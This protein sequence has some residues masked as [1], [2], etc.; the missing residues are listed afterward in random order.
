[1]STVVEAPVEMIERVTGSP[2]GCEAR[3]SPRRRQSAKE[4]GE[5]AYNPLTMRLMPSLIS[6]PERRF[7]YCR[8][9][10]QGAP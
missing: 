3:D 6:M 2:A 5:P 4:V 8:A 1:M 10:R 9:P 7:Q